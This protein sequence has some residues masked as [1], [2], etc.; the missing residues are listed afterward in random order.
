MSGKKGNQF[1]RLRSSHG[2]EKI[3]S[4]PDILRKA[5]E[6]YLAACEEK[7]FK[8]ELAFANGKKTT[9]NV[10]RAPTLKGLFIF[11]DIDRKTWKLYKEREDFI[12]II[13]SVE[14][15]IYNEKLTGAMAGLLKENL[16][17][18]ELGLADRTGIRFEDLSDEQIDQLIEKLVSNGKK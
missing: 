8:K 10:M 17:A 14:D 13:E 2:R 9:L 4:S 18:R 16:V 5:C 3:F 1:W 6:E 12:P 15:I 7:P 11:L